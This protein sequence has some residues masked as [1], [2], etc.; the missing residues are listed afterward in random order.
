[1]LL[2]LAENLGMVVAALAVAWT[3]S[4]LE[5]ASLRQDGGQKEP[6]S[7]GHHTSLGLMTSRSSLEK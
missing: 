7:L 3:V 1:M 4:D 5:D 6:G 2:P